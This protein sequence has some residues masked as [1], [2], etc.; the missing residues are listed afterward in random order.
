[1]TVDGLISGTNCH[2]DFMTNFFKGVFGSR[3]DDIR[4]ISGMEPNGQF[5][6]STW[7]DFVHV[8]IS[9]KCSWDVCHQAI[10]GRVFPKTS[11]LNRL[12]FVSNNWV[13]KDCAL[14]MSGC[15][16]QCL[17]RSLEKRLGRTN[18]LARFSKTLQTNVE[19]TT[20]LPSTN[21]HQEPWRPLVWEWHHDTAW[22]LHLRVRKGMA[23]RELATHLQQ[24]Y[25]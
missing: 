5:G 20:S 23:K 17:S 21:N 3:F 7:Q 12:S 18:P 11:S 24:V 16:G 14:K 8:S 10:H 9:I 19:Q 25:P 1:M 4:C 15:P 22:H 6:I 13:V 2:I